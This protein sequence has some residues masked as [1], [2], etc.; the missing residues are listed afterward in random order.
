VHFII[1]QTIIYEGHTIE[2]VDVL[3]QIGHVVYCLPV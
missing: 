2:Y 1:G 3:H